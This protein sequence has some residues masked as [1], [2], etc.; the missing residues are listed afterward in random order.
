MCTNVA[1]LIQL[2]GLPQ[3][4]LSY[5]SWAKMDSAQQ[6]KD[7]AESTKTV[8]SLHTAPQQIR[9]PAKTFIYFPNLVQKC[10]SCG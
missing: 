6:F 3:V 9:I 2:R 5:F 10:N 4:V 8:S 7:G 1:D